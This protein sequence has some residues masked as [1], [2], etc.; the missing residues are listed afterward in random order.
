MNTYINRSKTLAGVSS[1]AAPGRHFQQWVSSSPMMS[2][3]LHD[4]LV[5]YFW[6]FLHI[7]FLSI[8]NS[9]LIK[10]PPKI[11][12]CSV[13]FHI[14]HLSAFSNVYWNHCHMPRLTPQILLPQNTKSKKGK[15]TV[16]VHFPLSLGLLHNYLI[17]FFQR[18]FPHQSSCDLSKYQWLGWASRSSHSQEAL[19]G[20]PLKVSHWRSQELLHSLVHCS[21]TSSLELQG[22]HKFV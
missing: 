3:C 2:L 21:V 9:I 17:Q 4:S 12:H 20:F 19:K 11:I 14:L 7:A 16:S 5:T 13:S 10:Y 15:Q 22:G 6:H 1:K 8:S 18:D